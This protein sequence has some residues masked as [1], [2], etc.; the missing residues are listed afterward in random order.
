M[1][2]GRGRLGPQ[3]ELGAVLLEALPDGEAAQTKDG[4]HEKLLH[5]EDPFTSDKWTVTTLA[6]PTRRTEPPWCIGV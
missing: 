3:V 2:L 5:G 1:L 4:E 6:T